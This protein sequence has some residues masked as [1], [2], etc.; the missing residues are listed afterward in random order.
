MPL[1][2][3]IVGLLLGLLVLG[4]VIVWRAVPV[5]AL[6]VLLACGIVALAFAELG[7]GV[8]NKLLG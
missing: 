1:A 2:L 5:L 6:I 8:L 7:G 4:L 3:T